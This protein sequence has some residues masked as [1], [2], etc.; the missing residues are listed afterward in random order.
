MKLITS[1]TILI[2]FAVSGFSQKA[3]S[4]KLYQNTDIYKRFENLYDP[5]TR[6]RSTQGVSF[7]KFN[8]ISLALGLQ[9][10]KEWYH[11]IEFSYVNDFPPIEHTSHITRDSEKFNSNFDTYHQVNSSSNYFSFHYELNR[12]FSSNKLVTFQTGVGLT[13]YRSTSILEPEDEFVFRLT[14]KNL[15]TTLQLIP[16]IIFHLTDNLDIDL[17]AKIGLLNLNRFKYRIHNPA[18]PSD[19]QTI[20]HEWEVD[21]FPSAFNLRFG[22]VYQIKES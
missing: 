8:R 11:E 6:D 21:M 9:S 16:R 7:T 1:I 14:E 22:L 20:L 4:I 13:T 19:M 18:I 15:G 2:L 12:I 3:I 10:T 5:V 17:N